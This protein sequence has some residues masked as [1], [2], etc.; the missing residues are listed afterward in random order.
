MIAVMII[1]STFYQ[2]HC[3]GYWPPYSFILQI[4]SRFYPAD[5]LPYQRAQYQADR[6]CSQRNYFDFT[7]GVSWSN[8]FFG[9]SFLR[10][11]TFNCGKWSTF[12][13]H[14]A[15]IYGNFGTVSYLGSFFGEKNHRD[16]NRHCRCCPCCNRREF[17]YSRFSCRCGIREFPFDRGSGIVEHLQHADKKICSEIRQS[18]PH[19]DLHGFRLNL[20]IYYQYSTQTEF[21]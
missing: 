14:P 20:Y 17:Q 8:P 1:W 16:S 21:K 18:H 6:S 15:N 2:I 10:H 13:Q 12:N 7:S 19:L 11:K 9:W 3:R 5:S 4:F